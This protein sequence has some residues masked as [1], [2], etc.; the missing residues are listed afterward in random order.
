MKRMHDN[1]YLII[2]PSLPND[3]R[4]G[5]PTEPG[6]PD[7]TN[8]GNI[9][10]S[11]GSESTASPARP[12]TTQTEIGQVL[13]ETRTP[14]PMRKLINIYIVTM[15]AQSHLTTPLC[16]SKRKRV[17]RRL[18]PQSL[19]FKQKKSFKRK[20]KLK[21]ASKQRDPILQRPKNI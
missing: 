6:D 8:L 9:N 5:G 2:T 17:L 12:L 21:V 18:L 4:G 7:F 13:V 11:D 1:P 10:G 14:N 3:I 16:M 15:R 19:K 20:Q